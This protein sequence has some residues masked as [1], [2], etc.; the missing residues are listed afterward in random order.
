MSKK[1]THEEYIAELSV[2]NPNIEPLEQYISANTSILHR[3]KIDGFKWMARPG[4]ILFGKGCPMCAGNLKLTNEEYVSRLKVINPQVVPID[5]YINRCTSI[6]HMC[7]IDGYIWRTSPSSILSGRGC[8]KCAGNLHKTHDEYVCELFNINPNIIVIEQYIDAQ[9]KILHQCKI[10]GHVWR[11]A[12]TTILNGCGCPKCANKIRSMDFMKSHDE[13][14]RQLNDINQY[15]EVLEEYQGTDIPILHK[16]KLDGHEWHAR[17]HNV[18][19]G[20]GCPKCANNI[21]R[22]HSEYMALV[23][24]INPHIEVIG[25]YINSDTPILH[26]CKIDNNTWMVRPADIIKGRGCPRCS[27]SH[28]EKQISCWLVNQNIVFIAQKRF[29][30]CRN[31][32]ALPFDFYLP[33]YNICIE[34]DGI[35]HFEPVDFAGKGEEW[36]WQRF[37]ETQYNDEVKNQYCNNNN[38]ILLRIPYFKNIEEELEQFF[39]HLI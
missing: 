13:Y 15:I 14:V 29:D 21:R 23:E 37:K 7:L 39:I 12:P 30:G 24:K 11:V 3:C 6:T 33:E 2:K 20:V 25:D 9:T 32:N 27:Q 36:A 28:G 35:Q 31:K 19:N 22:T 4:N 10:D 38:I 16:C 26:R 8:P 5:A 1:K 18:L 34:Y 17:P